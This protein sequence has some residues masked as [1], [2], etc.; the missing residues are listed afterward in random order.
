MGKA[1]FSL[2]I[3]KYNAEITKLSYNTTDANTNVIGFATPTTTEE[4]NLYDE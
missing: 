2:E 3:T 1:R 4:D